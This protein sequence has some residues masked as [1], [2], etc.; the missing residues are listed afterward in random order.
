MSLPEVHLVAGTR[1]EA[2][3]LAP[4]T[5]A[6]HAAGLLAPVLVAG[7]R[8]PDRVASTFAAFDLIPDVTL[9]IERDT[10]NR[11]ELLTAI[12]GHLDALWAGRTPAAVLVQGDTTASLAGALAAGWRRIPVVHLAAGQRSREF[13]PPFPGEANRRL[14]AQLA[15]LHLAATPLAAMNLLDEHI[16]VGDVLITG[17][18][19]ADAALALAARRLPF[20]NLQVAAA[21]RA[22]S[23]SRLAVV[24]AHRRESWGAPLDRILAAVRRLVRRYAD[25]D[26]IL[27]G[28]P[29]PA[30]SAQIE[31][32]IGG[33]ARVTITD[34]LPYPDL[35]RLLRQAYLVLTD[36]DDLLEV[37]P[38]FGVPALAL[39]EVTERGE[40]LH[41]GCARHVGSDTDLIVREAGDLLDSRSL[42]DAMATA[43]NPYGDGLAAFRT[44][45]ATAAQLGLADWPEPMPALDEGSPSCRARQR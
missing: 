2:A 17:S 30:V 41:A 6:M 43:G 5:T 29:N 9:K 18:T 8:H 35:A 45:Q 19:T 26:V 22:G 31:A 37:A 16:A 40:A 13:D 7:A 36:S 25:L 3:R 21:V 14:V 39:R 32:G 10:G 33:I 27:P 1:A 11:A 28:H 23:A 20:E 15:T 44:A 12:I 34:P 4:V 42:H 38:A 24:T